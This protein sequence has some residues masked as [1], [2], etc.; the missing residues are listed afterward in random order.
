MSVNTS[1][2]G[3]PASSNTSSASGGSLPAS[4]NELRQKRLAALDRQAALAATNPKPASDNSDSAGNSIFCF[5]FEIFKFLTSCL[6][7]ILKI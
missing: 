1:S 7:S 5:V 4:Q 3:K 2:S 6:T